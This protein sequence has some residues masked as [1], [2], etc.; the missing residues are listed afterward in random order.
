MRVLVVSLLVFST[1]AYAHH[2]IVLASVAMQSMGG[3]V[4]VGAATVL[5]LREWLRDRL[6]ARERLQSININRPEG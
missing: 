3:L 4:V 6:R 2:E 1:P 5:G